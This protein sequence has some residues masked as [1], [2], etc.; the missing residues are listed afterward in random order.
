MAA[1]WG[2][3]NEMEKETGQTEKGA[4]AKEEMVVENILVKHN[5][6]VAVD[7]AMKDTVAVVIEIVRV[8]KEHG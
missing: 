5:M 1:E 7:T 3:K 4:V 8:R 6:T 2:V